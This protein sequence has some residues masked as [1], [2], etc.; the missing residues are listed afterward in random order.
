M[1]LASRPIIRKSKLLNEETANLAW[2]NLITAA[3]RMT[4]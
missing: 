3:A 1:S 2:V 4:L